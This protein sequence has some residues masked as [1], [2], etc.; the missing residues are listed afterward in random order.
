MKRGQFLSHE[1]RGNCSAQTTRR[2]SSGSPRRPDFPGSSSLKLTITKFV[3]ISQIYLRDTRQIQ[4]GNVHVLGSWSMRSFQASSPLLLGLN[5]QGHYCI[6]HANQ[7]IDRGVVSSMWFRRNL[8]LLIW[9][10]CCWPRIIWS[11]WC[12][13]RISTIKRI[14]NMLLSLYPNMYLIDYHIIIWGL[15]PEVHNTK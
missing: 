9:S 10:T 1:S 8:L 11:T 6:E 14:R 4:S 13:A 2:T 15:K 7:I 5:G 12:W 3:R